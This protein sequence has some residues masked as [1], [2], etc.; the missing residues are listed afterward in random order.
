MA[1]TALLML[2]V[3]SCK[4]SSTDNETDYT[5]EFKTQSDDHTFMSSDN[6]EVTAD[7]NTVLENDPT[8][9]GRPLYTI[10]GATVASGSTSTT[11]TVTITYNGNNCNNKRSRVGVVELSIPK[12]KKWKDVGTVLTVK[13]VNLK[14]TRLSSTAPKSITINGSEMY[15]NTSGGKLLDVVL[16]NAT[17]THDITSSGLSLT[18]DDGSQRIWEVSKRRVYSNSGGNVTLTITGTHSDGTNSDIAEWGTNRRGKVFA[19]RIVEPIVMKQDCEFRIGSGKICY[20]KF[21]VPVYLTLG[22]N[23]SGV[24]TTCPG[25]S[26]LY[27]LKI[28]WNKLNGTAQSVLLAY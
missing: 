5:E 23:A 14:I 10:C 4:K 21:V 3:V 9:A 17:I 24:A 27:Y 11:R 8:L 2:T 12:N 19:A 16:N 18:F 13:F 1:F 26:N 6:D 15:T 7:A 28:E 22:L 25:T 20:T